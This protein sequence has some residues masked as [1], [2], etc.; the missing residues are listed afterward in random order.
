MLED[1][2][3]PRRC[4]HVDGKILLPLGEYLAKLNAVLDH[5][6]SICVLARTDAAGT[7]MYR[8]VEAIQKTDA[9]AILVDGIESLEALR[10]VRTLTDK[11]VAFNQ[12]AG[13]K[14]PRLSA[15]ELRA[16]GVA[17]HIYSTPM[18]LA[19]QAAMQAAMSEII[20]ADGR[21][22]VTNDGVH[23]AAKDCIAVL[24]A[25]VT[26]DRTQPMEVVNEVEAL[27]MNCFAQK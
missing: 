17:V 22:P 25:N 20:D 18:L 6:H 4:G 12:M 11:P 1:Q 9:D 3:R 24:Q 23:L 19:A 7:E 13:G 27:R 5:R 21:L 15:A 16:E 14:S 2:A 8:R 10:H 26:S